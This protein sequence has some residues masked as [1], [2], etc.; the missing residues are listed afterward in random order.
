M[1]DIPSEPGQ[2][3]ECDLDEELREIAVGRFQ[4]WLDRAREV[5]ENG[6]SGEYERRK[7]YLWGQV[8]VGRWP[9][10]R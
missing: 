4:E 5:V 10:G 6:G 8:H 2:T 9:G 3:T 7:A 1:R